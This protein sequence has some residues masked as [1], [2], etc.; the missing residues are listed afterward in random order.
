MRKIR[1]VTTNIAG[2]GEAPTHPR[3]TKIGPVPVYSCAS[4]S[5]KWEICR[6]TGKTDVE[7]ETETCEP[8]RRVGA[9]WAAE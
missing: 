2:G 6:A 1:A 9:A 8:A 7:T 5:N 4:R 3:A